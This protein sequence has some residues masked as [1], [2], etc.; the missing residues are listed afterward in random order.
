MDYDQTTWA[1]I[2]YQEAHGVLPNNG[3]TPGVD[4]DPSDP[5][6]MEIM[7]IV[8]ANEKSDAKDREIQKLK[9]RNAALR[10]TLEE[11]GI[12]LPE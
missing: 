7:E 6:E 10:A 12:E 1:D 9:H 5:E 2:R 3:W 11:H 8:F 4:F